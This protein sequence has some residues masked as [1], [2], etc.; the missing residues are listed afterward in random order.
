M[1]HGQ[2][3]GG[4]FGFGLAAQW[5]GIENVWYNEI[6][7]FCCEVV[8]ARIKDGQIKDNVKIY[9]QDIRE[10]GKHNLQRVDIISGGFPCQP[11]SQAGKRKGK[12]DD[13][14]L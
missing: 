12:T 5:A 11:F 8:R 14:Y 10:I 6:D 7:H 1:T 4:I 9:E 2:L 3:F 13:R